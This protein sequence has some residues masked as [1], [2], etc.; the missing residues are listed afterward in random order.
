MEHVP[1]LSQ[2]F[3]DF[4]KIADEKGY[5][6]HILPSRCE[7]TFEHW[8]AKSANDGIDA[9]LG[10]RYYYEHPGHLR[11]LSAEEFG[12]YCIDYGFIMKK[13]VFSNKIFGTLNWISRTNLT[14]IR[15]MFNTKRTNQTIYKF[16]FL[17]LQLF[18]ITSS[19]L[20]TPSIQLPKAFS[21]RK[22]S[23]R[24]YLLFLLF[25]CM[26]PGSFI[27]DKI[28]SFFAEAEWRLYREAGS[29]MYLFFKR[30]I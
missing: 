9:D 28:I 10:N 24:K 5:M 14:F 16:L 3:N 26:Y 29:E 20:R 11:R 19:L 2:V 1:V 13:K 18:F 23:K 25:L 4:E 7:N 8:V 12:T 17:I 27:F 22:K 6:I 30:T 21:K 15:N